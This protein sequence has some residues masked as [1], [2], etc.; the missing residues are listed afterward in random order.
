[1][2]KFFKEGYHHQKGHFIIGFLIKCSK[3]NLLQEILFLKKQT[4]TPSPLYKIH[5]QFELNVNFCVFWNALFQKDV[6]QPPRV[7]NFFIK[8]PRV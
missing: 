3:H 7:R 6:L 2:S 4:G 1:M 5:F 8:A